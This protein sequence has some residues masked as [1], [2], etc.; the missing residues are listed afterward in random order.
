MKYFISSSKFTESF[1]S[2]PEKTGADIIH[3]GTVQEII[4]SGEERYSKR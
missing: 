2:L 4:Q 3:S 1:H